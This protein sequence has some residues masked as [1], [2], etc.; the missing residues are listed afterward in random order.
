M[1][2]LKLQLKTT[3]YT[4]GGII[5][6]KLPHHTTPPNKSMTAYNNFLNQDYRQDGCLELFAL[7]VLEKKLW[8]NN[9]L[10][11]FIS[12]FKNLLRTG[13]SANLKM[14]SS[15]WKVKVGEQL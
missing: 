7:E 6:S 14:K 1:Q 2:Q 3:Q 4:Y 11:S 5:I 8:I 13:G 15:T 10:D 9:E 12:K